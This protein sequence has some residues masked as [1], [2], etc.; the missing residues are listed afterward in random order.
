MGGKSRVPR[1]QPGQGGQG[2]APRNQA[3]N[4]GRVVEG[5]VDEPLFCQRGDDQGGVA[6]RSSAYCLAGQGVSTLIFLARFSSSESL[7]LWP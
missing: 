4:R 5:V 3:E 1:L 7:K 2:K 6:A